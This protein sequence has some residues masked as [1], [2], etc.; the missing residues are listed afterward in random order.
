MIRVLVVDDHSLVRSALAHLLRGA[1]D[2]ELV[3]EARD[4]AEAVALVAETQPDVVLMDLSMPIMDGVTATRLIC[5]QHPGV[6][7]VALTAFSER[8]TVLDALDA[9]AIGYVLKDGEMDELLRATRVAARGESPLSPAAAHVV[10]T[11]RHAR[12]APDLT[13]RERD[14]MR[15]VITG[16]TNREIAE[17]LAISEKTV[18]THLTRVYQRFG[19]RNRT[20][21]IEW[22]RRLGVDL[23]GPEQSSRGAAR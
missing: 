21:A 6:R 10:L 2:V 17:R 7:V 11:A 1:D 14:V 18:K 15:L 22:A 9:G 4:G 16:V 8:K 3:G 20:D 19:L 12:A 5:E 23:A 13:G